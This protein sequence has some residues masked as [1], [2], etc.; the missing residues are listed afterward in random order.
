M[1]NSNKIKDFDNGEKMERKKTLVNTIIACV[2]IF[3]SP[4]IIF[5][6]NL[7]YIPNLYKI[8]VLGLFVLL[9]TFN[10]F[11]INKKLLIF[12]AV[13][14]TYFLI[15]IFV[16]NEFFV[17]IAYFLQGFLVFG[18]ITI[19]FFSYKL[20][21]DLFLSVSYKLAIINI[22]LFSISYFYFNSMNY[23]NFGV[24]ILFSLIFIMI[25]Y[26]KYRNLADL[27]L[28]FILVPI[29]FVFANR[30]TSLALLLMVLYLLYIAIKNPYFR[31]LFLMLVTFIS[32][33][34]IYNLALILQ[35]LINILNKYGVDSYSIIKLQI[36]IEDGLLESSSGRD[37]IY[38]NVIRLIQDNNYMPIAYGEFTSQIG[39]NY[40]HNIIFELIFNFG[41]LGIFI[42]T[43]LSYFLIKKIILEENY[44][45][46]H[47]LLLLFIMMAI[48][49]QLSGSFWLETNFWIL[50]AIVFWSTFNTYNETS[51]RKS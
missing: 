28:V 2:F 20:D 50:L 7:V 11:K 40:P 35:S 48:R 18:V 1:S 22:L 8:T 36:M 30:S 44:L 15:S 42:F 29:V 25:H 31:V 21:F 26:L 12:T 6:N 41:F 27:V 19:L 43:F 17:D 3:L 13:I 33:H 4:Y 45:L 9:V 34:F 16:S 23:M 39:A 47:F 32:Y 51:Q 5:I 14:I 49:L 38:T 46:K 37:S 10:G 24:E